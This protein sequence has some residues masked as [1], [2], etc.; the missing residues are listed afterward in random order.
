VDLALLRRDRFGP[1]DQQRVPSKPL[2]VLPAPD[3]LQP[4]DR[5]APARSRPFQHQLAPDR[6]ARPVGQEED[7]P[8]SK[9]VGRA[10][11]LDRHQ[12]LTRQA[13]RAPDPRDD[14]VVHPDSRLA[15]RHRSLLLGLSGLRVAHRNDGRPLI[16]VTAGHGL[17]RAFDLLPDDLGGV[18][19]HL[20]RILDQLRRRARR[21]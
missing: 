17:H 11:G 12:Q 18:L 14:Q 20:A 7:T 19:Q 9:D 16:V 6:L 2:R 3:P 13:V 8:R 21:R 5:T 10:I 1:L 15:S 4:E